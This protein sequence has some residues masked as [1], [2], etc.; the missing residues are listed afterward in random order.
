MST[1][2]AAGITEVISAAAARFSGELSVSASNLLTGE[3]VEVNAF[4]VMPTA[5]VI[6]QPVLV[7]LLRAAEA[8]SVDLGE[9]MTMTADDR[10]GGSGILKVFAAGLQP[11]VEDVATLMI[12][13]SDNTATNMIIDLIGG[14]EVVNQAM[15]ALDLPGIELINRIDFDIIVD[16]AS[17]L[18]LS[19]T[20]DMRVLNELIAT[21]NAF[22][23]FVSRET[24]RIMRTQQYLDQGLRYVLVNPYAAE[25]GTT[26]EIASASKTGFISGVR[27]DS[28]IVRFAAGGGFVYSLANRGSIDRSF[29]PEAEGSVVNGYIGRALTE[30]WWPGETG[31]APVADSALLAAWAE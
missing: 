4:S 5:S 7:A 14:V 22:S 13:L 20:H 24:E 30:Y 27:V 23:P 2:G 11:T 17:N 12:A 6:K 26:A 25:L 1:P 19:N 16:D 10:V 31:T 28:A 3:V 9:R 18:A 15:S 21:E 8:G 29:L